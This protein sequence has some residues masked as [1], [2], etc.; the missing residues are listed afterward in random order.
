MEEGKY[1]E[2]D[3][4]T[5]QYG[6][7]SLTLGNIY[8]NYVLDLWFEKA[9]KRQLVGYDRLIRYGDESKINEEMLRQRL[10]KF[11]L[12]I[13][14][15][16]SRVIGFGRYEWERVGQ[17]CGNKMFLSLYRLQGM[18]SKHWSWG[19]SSRPT[20]SFRSPSS[21]TLDRGRPMV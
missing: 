9:V 8:L 13:A 18:I 2:V 20:G 10:G 15:D 16:K 12:K 6:M 21:K 14:D 5:P 4:G 19:N 17:E 1:V 3:R 11:G 7:I